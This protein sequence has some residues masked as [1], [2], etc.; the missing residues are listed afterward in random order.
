[1]TRPERGSGP[2]HGDRPPDRSVVTEHDRRRLQVTRRVA[3][4]GPLTGVVAA[5]GLAWLGAG[6]AAGMAALLVLSAASSVLAAFVTAVQAMIDEYRWV[7]VA[8][9][10]TWTALALFL[11]S[12]LL[13]ILSAAVASTV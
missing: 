6:G 12:F 10:R 3:L 4:A 2:G 9:R 13:L 1:M 8:R 11:A 5:A 7:P